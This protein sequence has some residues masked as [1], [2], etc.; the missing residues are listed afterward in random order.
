MRTLFFAGGCDDQVQRCENSKNGSARADEKGQ[1]VAEL[2]QGLQGGP[3]EVHDRPQDQVGAPAEDSDGRCQVGLD[4]EAD[5]EVPGGRLHSVRGLR[6]RADFRPAPEG[7]ARG[8]GR[9]RAALRANRRGHQRRAAT[10]CPLCGQHL[11]EKAKSDVSV[12]AHVHLTEITA[13]AICA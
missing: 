12:C 10:E 9:V 2:S 8:G 3:R 5:A 6:R 1:G 11:P 4:V 7:A 13:K